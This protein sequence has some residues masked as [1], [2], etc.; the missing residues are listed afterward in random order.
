MSHA[1]TDHL[2]DELRRRFA[3]LP[4]VLDY[5]AAVERNVVDTADEFLVGAGRR[6]GEGEA[7]PAPGPAADPTAML[8]TISGET[9]A[10]RRFRV[11]VLV[12]HAGSKGAPV[13]YEDNPTQP[14]LVGRAEYAAQLGALVTDFTLIRAGA[15]HR[16]NGGYLVL[17]ALR[18]LQQPYAWEALKRALRSREIRIETQG[19]MLSM[20]STLSLEPAPIP[21]ELKVALVGDRMLYYLLAASDPD[22]LELFKVQA[23]FEQQVERTP[24]TVA[25]YARLLATLAR[26]ERLLPLEAGAVARLLDEAARIAGDAAKLSTHMRSLSDLLREADH[27]AAV[28]G[29]GAIRAPDVERAIEARRRRAGRVRERVLEEIRDGTILIA[30]DGE[31]VGEVNGLSVLQLGDFA[32]GQPSRIT[33]VVRLG[34]GEVVDIEREV[35]L[36][37]P[38]HSKGVLILA[39][40]LGS[41]YAPDR[42]LTL[43]ASLVFEQSYAGVEGDSASLAELCALI[44]SI[45]ELPLRQALAVTGSVDQHG[46]VQP[47]GGVN[48]KIE[49]FFDVCASRALTG[50]QGVVI[51]APNVRHLMLADDVVAAVR[52]GKFWVWAV[53]TVDQALELLTGLPAGGRLPDGSWPEES[54]NGRVAERLAAL[55]DRAREFSVSATREREGPGA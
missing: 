21:L 1:A 52:T 26:R 37:G 50:L 33:A 4:E 19:Q 6:E 34:R 18:L 23:D 14:N 54:I 2:V 36:G 10:F 51:P 27:Y 28:S 29:G 46:R 17:D 9:P 42:P 8:R 43:H 31:V 48:E 15:L 22:F 12:D 24:E 45:G 30:T 53:E 16:A 20:V 40:F 5:L 3:D 11:N 32:F 49:A 25:T 47:V 35:E 41:R 38:L 44:S 55:A 7:G 13:V 39:G